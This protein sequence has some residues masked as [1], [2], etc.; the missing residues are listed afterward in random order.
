MRKKTTTPKARRLAAAAS[1][2]RC[3]ALA[4]P[5]TVGATL[6][7]PASAIFFGDSSTALAVLAI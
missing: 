1:P 4:V 2:G 3:P 7:A 6:A 5:A